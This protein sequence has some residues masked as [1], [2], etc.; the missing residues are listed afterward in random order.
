MY[1]ILVLQSFFV[2]LKREVKAG[3]TKYDKDEFEKLV[4]QV[5]K[6]YPSE[7]LEAGWWVM[8]DAYRQILETEGK[9]T[10]PRHRG[11]RKARAA[12]QR[13]FNQ[14][15]PGFGRQKIKTLLK[16]TSDWFDDNDYESEKEE[17]QV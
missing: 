3:P 13:E 8:A 1:I 6:N 5:Y 15:V 10:S 16:K 12:G 14:R 4:L 17:E 7:K 9:I 2:T 11:D